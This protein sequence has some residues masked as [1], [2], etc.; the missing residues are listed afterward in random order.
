MRYD[1][2]GATIAIN[3]EVATA[4]GGN[5]KAEA[6][7][8]RPAIC[9]LKDGRVLIIG[10]A[11]PLQMKNSSDRRCRRHQNPAIVVPDKVGADS[12]TPRL[13]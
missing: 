8:L 7:D 12:A 9:Q 6:C 1:G 11:L 2:S 3:L 4:Q 13:L 5:L 10:H